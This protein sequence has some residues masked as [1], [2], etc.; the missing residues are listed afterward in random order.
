MNK[1]IFLDRDGTIII[2]KEYLYRPEEVE[3]FPWSRQALE[4]MQ[5]S[6]Y[7]LFIVSNQSGIGR[8]YFK[9]EDAH[10]V[11]QR[12]QDDMKSWG[13]NIFTAISF[14]PHTTQQ[15]CKCRKPEPQMLIDLIAKYDIDPKESY[16]VGDKTADV[17]AGEKSGVTPVLLQGQSKYLKGDEKLPKHTLLYENLLEFAQKL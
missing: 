13:L 2:D 17:W 3:Y 7:L 14:C 10:K 8:G 11:H 4:I 1:A 5:N 15:K 16:M 6:G 12:I 9:E